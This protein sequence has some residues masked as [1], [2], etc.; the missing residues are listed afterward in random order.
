MID[1]EK[2]GRK[3]NVIKRLRLNEILQNE[4]KTYFETSIDFGDTRC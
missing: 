3:T 1:L 2:T 4:F